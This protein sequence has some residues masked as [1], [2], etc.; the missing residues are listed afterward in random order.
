MNGEEDILKKSKT[1]CGISKMFVDAFTLIE[2]LV[3]IAIIGILAA[4]LLPALNKAREKARATLCLGNMRQWGLAVGMYA[5]EW[6]DYLPPEGVGA[7]MNG[8]PY[9]WYNVLP[10]YIG[11]TSLITLYSQ[12]KPPTPQ[13]K[14][15]YSCPSDSYKG[16]PTDAQPYYMYGMNNRMDPNG[17]A[18]FKRAQVDKPTDTIMF[19]EN[20]GT[21]SATNGKYA[22][23][24]HSG[25]SNLTFVDGHAQWVRFADW[26]RNGNT[27]CPST[28]NEYDSSPLTGDW[29]PE[30]KIHWFPFA[31]APT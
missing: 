27:G 30:V 10:P 21:F 15:I 20:N 2:L 13:S 18:L 29:R 14:S 26:C 28:I 25:G 16:T 17:I 6:Q 8:S 24:R 12:N 1:R 23:A 22:P 31:N 3:V 11:A 19:C 4:M 7:P 5:D 9:A